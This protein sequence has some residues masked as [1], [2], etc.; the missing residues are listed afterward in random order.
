MMYYYIFNFTNKKFVEIFLC[1]YVNTHNISSIKYLPFL[2]KVS[3]C[4]GFEPDFL[5][6]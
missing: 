4:L 5:L 2:E 1:S 6:T 3:K